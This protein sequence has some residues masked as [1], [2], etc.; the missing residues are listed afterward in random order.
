[1]FVGH[2]ERAEM[3]RVFLSYS[4]MDKGLANRLASDLRDEGID[5]WFDEWR[6]RVGDSIT[7]AIQH[8]LADADF[9]LVLLS[10]HSVASGWVQKEW[11]SQIGREA[12]GKGTIILPIRLDACEIPPLLADKKYAD[13]GLDYR[14]ALEEIVCAIAANSGEH[15][16]DTRVADAAIASTPGHNMGEASVVFELISIDDNWKKYWSGGRKPRNKHEDKTHHLPSFD[17]DVTYEF[18]LPG[19]YEDID[20]Q[21]DLTILNR[22]REPVVLA[23]VGVAVIRLAHYPYFPCAGIPA[24]AKIEK[25]AHYV[26]PVPDTIHIEKAE[27]ARRHTESRRDNL[28]R[29]HWKGQVG[30]EEYY[31]EMFELEAFCI[32]IEAE[33][34]VEFGDPVYL[35]SEAPFRFTALLRHYCRNTA[36]YAVIKFFLDMTR[37]RYYSPSISMSN[38]RM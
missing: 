2:T 18:C 1:V 7:Q 11:Q 21:F 9:V 33:S 34:V 25:M 5:V 24:A 35:Q 15:R 20:P 8:G 28:E 27:L 32:D 26:I 12:E 30:Y 37:S 38:P 16:L 10:T 23:K 36:R 31:R 17:R 4:S 3:P 6:I 13:I 29:R 19:R 22:T 14:Q